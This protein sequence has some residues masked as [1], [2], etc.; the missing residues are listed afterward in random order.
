MHV[1][2]CFFIYPCQLTLDVFMM[3]PIFIITIFICAVF[4]VD[5]GFT[6]G[7][8]L[9]IGIKVLC[10]FAVRHQGQEVLDKSD[11]LSSTP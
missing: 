8:G 3:Y 11:S 7:I 10:T 1:E 4:F 2:R 6:T 5:Y 9:P